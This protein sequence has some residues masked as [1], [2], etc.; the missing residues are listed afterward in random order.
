MA[1]CLINEKLFN[2]IMSQKHCLF[3]KKST[4]T[5]SLDDVDVLLD[6][7]SDRKMTVHTFFAKSIGKTAKSH[8]K[9]KYI[10]K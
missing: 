9:K 8:D 4:K 6:N 7:D 5:R 3:V 2:K 10:S 1:T